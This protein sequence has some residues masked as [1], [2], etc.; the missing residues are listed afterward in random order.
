MK[1]NHW[2]LTT[3]FMIGGGGLAQADVSN[4]NFQGALGPDYQSS[5]VQNE[6]RVT[7]DKEK[8]NN[9]EAR[10]ASL[11]SQLNALFRGTA[12]SGKT[13]H[14]VPAPYDREAI[15][16]MN[17]WSSEDHL[18]TAQ[19]KVVYSGELK[20]KIQYLQ[21]RIDRFTQK[22]YLDT[23]GLKRAKLNRIL[24]NLQKE[25]QEETAKLAWHKSQAK[26][27]MVS[28]SQNQQAS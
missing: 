11:E 17:K 8:I 13:P 16:A 28:Q 19:E 1:L 26:Q 20:A 24:G 5:T 25:L 2:I 6:T 9:L 7:D 3:M 12:E 18:I 4:P 22:P 14:A 21:D 10:I 15:Q 23:K 27:T